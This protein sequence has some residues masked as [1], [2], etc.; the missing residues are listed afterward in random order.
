MTAPFTL[1]A[2]LLRAAER[3]GDQRAVSHGALA[4]SY[5]TLAD[6]AGRVAAALRDL[7]VRPGDRVAVLA[8]KAPM[9]VAALYGTLGAGAVCVPV[10]PLAPPLRAG[11]II[12]DA[13]CSAICV[14]GPRDER[15]LAA[16]DADAP[17]LALSDEVGSAALT[18]GELDTCTP[19][20]LRRGC[21]TDLAYLLYTSG[22]TGSPKGV[23]LSHRNMLAFAEWAVD[24]FGIT[25]GDRLSN[26]APFHF[27]LSVLDLYGAALAGAAVHLVGP[28]EG[29]LGASTAAVI[30][31]HELTVWYSVPSALIALCEV[32]TEADLASLRTIL[33][34]GEVFP[35][36]RLRRLRELAPTAVIANLYG[37]TE[38]NVCTYYVVPERLDADAPIPIG[39]AC[40]NQEVF[41]LD[42]AGRLVP[43]GEPG[44]LYVRG[45]TVMKGYWGQPQ[46]TAS[47]LRQSPLHQRFADP[48]Y[49]TGDLVRRRPEGELEFLG[50]RDHQ[51]KSRGY[52]IELGEIEAALVSHDAVREAAVVAVPDERIGHALIAYVAGDPPPGESEIKHHCAQRVPR[53]MVPTRINAMPGL[54]HTS[55]GK[56]DRQELTRLVAEGVEVTR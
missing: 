1:H 45:P 39:R 13:E 37:P 33:F 48:A 28:G 18:R 7:G 25:S 22:S 52:R 32:A 41:L 51:I 56:I 29:A 12:A 50:R 34:A 8:D 17:V 19:A 15:T 20:T 21:E 46:L 54:P 24:R 10:D 3:R 30:R 9:T 40:E 43:D 42:D 2:A 55:T 27:D 47:A 44:E 26:H 31:D 11:R 5:A 14:G 23:M 4:W 35:T 49:R 38:T 53:Y 16:A 6:A 36:R